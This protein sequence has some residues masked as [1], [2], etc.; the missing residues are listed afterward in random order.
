VRW[1]NISSHL[2]LNA[3]ADSACACSLLHVKEFSGITD[4]I[5]PIIDWLAQCR[6]PFEKSQLY[7]TATESKLIDEDKRRSLVPCHHR[8]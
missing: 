6:Q 3:C 7:S 4:S 2:I 5:T 8:R 1:N